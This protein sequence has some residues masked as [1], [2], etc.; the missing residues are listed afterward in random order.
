MYLPIEEQ[1]FLLQLSKGFQY[2]LPDRLPAGVPR[3]SFG[4]LRQQRPCPRP[5][6]QGRSM[7]TA[8]T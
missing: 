8:V 1:T 3:Q 7:R 6:V 4:R 2:R 5:A